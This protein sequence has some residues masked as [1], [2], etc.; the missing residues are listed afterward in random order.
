[1]VE[2]LSQAQGNAAAAARLA[3]IRR[4]HMHKVIRYL[5]LRCE[6]YRPAKPNYM[7]PEHRRRFAGFITH[8]IRPR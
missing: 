5:G 6:D 1:M 3:G 4:Q 2:A 7:A 8:A